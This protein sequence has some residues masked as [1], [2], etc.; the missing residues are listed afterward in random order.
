MA[1]SAKQ[2]SL[3]RFT[4]PNGV[5]VGSGFLFTPR[6]MLCAASSVGAALGMNILPPEAPDE[7]VPVHL[8][9]D[10][11]VSA[12]L[13]A[14]RPPT[15][16][17]ALDI[18][19]LEL[20]HT[21]Y[22]SPGTAPLAA[23][24]GPPG[25]P[26]QTV[27]YTT[28]KE[29]GP[30]GALK[31]QVFEVDIFYQEKAPQGWVKAQQFDD[32]CDLRLPGS[33]GAPVWL[34]QEVIGLLN[35]VETEQGMEP[36]IIPLDLVAQVFGELPVRL[37][38]DEPGE[39][40]RSPGLPLY[41]VPRA[42]EAHLLRSMLLAFHKPSNRPGDIFGATAFAGLSGTGPID[43]MRSDRIVIHGNPGTGKTTFTA[44][45]LR[46]EFIRRVYTDGI[47]WLTLGQNPDLVR[48]QAQLA[49]L[50]GAPY[51][52]FQ[53]PHQGRRVLRG[54]MAEKACL[55]VL[56]AVWE[57]EDARMFDCLGPKGMLLVV[58]R[59]TGLVGSLQAQNVHLGPLTDVQ[60][61]DLF[62][63][64]ADLAEKP[65]PRIAKQVLA[66]CEGL[67]LAI[68]LLGSVYKAY[69]NSG[70]EIIAQAAGMNMTPFAVRMANYFFKPL[71]KGLDLA[72]KYLP[73]EIRER[74]NEL[75][76]FPPEVPL[77]VATLQTLWRAQGV[78]K[79][80][81][82]DIILFLID[83]GLLQPDQRLKPTLA[84]CMPGAV[85]AY[86]RMTVGDLYGL[87]L[88]FVQ[89]YGSLPPLPDGYIMGNLIRH[90]LE[91]NLY[92]QVRGLLVN[93]TYLARRLE[94]G[95]LAGLLEDYRLALSSPQLSLWDREQGSE[96]LLIIQTAIMLSAPQVGQNLRALA[97]QLMGRLLG[98]ADPDVQKL[99][100]SVRSSL[101]KRTLLPLSQSLGWPG[102]HQLLNLL[103]H[104][105]PVRSLVI[106]LDGQLAVSASEDKTIRVWDLD[107]GQCRAV[108][109]GHRDI[110]NCLAMTPDGQHLLS[111][112]DDG[113]LILWNLQTAMPGRILREDLA[114]HGRLLAIS[115]SADGRRVVASYGDRSILLWDLENF[116]L[117]RTYQIDES[118][119][120][121]VLILPGSLK[122]ASAGRAIN[123]WDLETG[124][125]MMTLSGHS[126]SVKTMITSND[127]Q[128]LITAADDRSIRIWDLQTGQE[129]RILSH[130]A[131]PVLA[132]APIPG[133]HMII[134]GG[135]DKL[136]HT[137]DIDSGRFVASF[138]A[139]A[140]VVR[141]LAIT[142]DGS[143][144]VS[145]GDDRQ[146]CVWDQSN[147]R[148]LN[149]LS[150]PIAR[151]S[152]VILT[153]DGRRAISA[154]VDGSIRL[155]ELAN[156][157]L[158]RLIQEKGSNIY[159]LALASDGRRLVSASSDGTITLFDLEE[160]FPPVQMNEHGGAVLG[161][162]LT[163]DG[164]R[165]V[166][167][168][169]D[170]TVR[171][172]DIEPVEGA[173]MGRC[174]LVATMYGHS[175]W[176]RS[177]ACLPDNWRAVSVSADGTLKLWDLESGS[178]ILSVDAHQGEVNDVAVLSHGKRV[179]TAGDDHLLRVWDI[180]TGHPQFT[181]WGHTG[182][183]NAV[184]ATLDGARIVSVS[185]DRS[186]RV[187]DLP[188][189]VK[190]KPG[191][192]EN[193][194]GPVVHPALIL[195]DHSDWIHTVAISADGARAISASEDTTIKIWDISPHG[196]A[197]LGQKPALPPEHTGGV[198]A[199]ALSADGRFGVSGGADGRLCF[200]HFERGSSARIEKVMAK[201][202]LP[203]R[204]S[205]TSLQFFPDGVHVAAGSEDRLLRIWN[206]S[207]PDK[208]VRVLGGLSAAARKVVV[209]P[210][211]CR[212]CTA[213]PSLANGERL[214]SAIAV[215]DVASGELLHVFED[216]GAP[217]LM[218]ACL[219]DGRR[220]AGFLENG[221]FV[222]WDLYADRLSLD[223]PLLAAKPGSSFQAA[224]FDPQTRRLAAVN[225]GG[226]ATLLDLAGLI[227]SLG[228]KRKNLPAVP[229]PLQLALPPLPVR[230][231]AWTEKGGS[232]AVLSGPGFWL[233]DCQSGEQKAHFTADADLT[234]CA[235]GTI[236][237]LHLLGDRAGRIH[238]LGFE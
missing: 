193:L 81:S 133:L 182:E 78:D 151:N 19:V 130:H 237:N 99:L 16:G 125:I 61:E 192:E 221:R 51:A 43:A 145:A 129:Q 169:A 178:L 107:S 21:Y 235:C 2:T 106:S 84:V 88:Q 230:E 50:M 158:V 38:A 115:G 63:N 91:S 32:R 136:L 74:L 9:D 113:D 57:G 165:A 209:T 207:Q 135:M 48:L 226:G 172:W 65:F 76:I 204:S 27:C 26:F 124:Q 160:T 85:S 139:H 7:S 79:A 155:W 164:R 117:M 109:T 234:A 179:V 199:L 181:L 195:E 162:A 25:Q 229:A 167:S 80:T 13:L 197:S 100:N 163:P 202:T 218:L 92:E 15:E 95:G 171:I 28:G 152:A 69:P 94:D 134:S 58:G 219:P 73:V 52:I 203:G 121:A 149:S 185:H 123:I 118:I 30:G 148:L 127:G 6:R 112:S 41:F 189:R 77:P 187:W 89:A 186:V 56:D 166:S 217:L 64:A 232:L 102:K 196:N 128:K 87:H 98:Y 108:L 12:R 103:G 132:M 116:R 220:A 222:V 184:A 224:A 42:G 225:G 72:V 11:V 46:D 59:E 55:L 14:W 31:S 96:G 238:F 90:M 62:A 86:L 194:T 37:P 34:D 111:G 213:G 198:N 36:V 228:G 60:S 29:E 210:D 231:M 206:L 175:S 104:K 18:A 227:N 17:L 33:L 44:S 138:E 142:P 191:S 1:N 159:A 53:D 114:E 205:L 216:L 161:V 39:V 214:D 154:S 173:E 70:G 153:A 211:G 119:A 144:L 233:W 83:R 146:I 190:V 5:P 188:A 101:K 174:E 150:G 180:E 22:G 131:G 71:I 93:F 35:L 147:R 156:G 23:L 208:P 236:G 177:V 120:D 3:V 4:A 45:V 54:L 75:A 49:V 47:I 67:P 168:S 201:V 140:G 143:K 40:L 170:A 8:S 97:A 157:R 122:A 200:W 223:V 215:W 137:W 10:Q 176:V 126:G 105:G 141:C 66:Q 24:E 82:Q 110:V 212:I 20:D 183:V 68:R